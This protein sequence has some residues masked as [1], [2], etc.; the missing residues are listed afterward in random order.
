MDSFETFSVELPGKDAFVSRLNGCGI[1]DKDYEHAVEVWKR[2][3]MSN[4]GEYHDLYLKTDVLLLADVFEGFQNLCECHYEL[5]PAHYYTTPGLAWDAML[6]M[7]GV[8]L[9]LLNNEEMLLVIERGM[10][11]GNSN[12]FCRFSPRRTTNI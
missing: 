4:M 9:E 10:R 8:E 1:S 12:A 6:K 11:G 5:D 3:G 2:F 7:T